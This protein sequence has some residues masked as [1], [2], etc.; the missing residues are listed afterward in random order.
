MIH[1]IATSCTSPA[2]PKPTVYLNGVI[3]K[4]TMNVIQS[5]MS[6]ANTLPHAPFIAL[7]K[8]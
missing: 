6:A 3:P 5:T 4:Q 1:P 2:R 8:I 7:R